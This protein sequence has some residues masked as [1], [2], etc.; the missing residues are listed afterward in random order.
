MHVRK[1]KPSIVYWLGNNIY[2][3]LTNKCSNNCYF[4]FRKYK[5]GIQDFNLRL[6]KEPTTE[7]IIEEILK[8]I[9]RRNW[10]EIVFCGFGEPLEKLDVV[11][12]VTKWIKKNYWN[13]VRVDTNGQGYLLNK[14]RDVVR[15]LKEARVDKF[16]ISLNAQNK[17]TYN[18]ICKPAF[19]YAYESVLEFIK[20]AKKAGIETVITAVSIPEIDISKIKEQA[21]RMG[22]KF[23][24]RKYIPFFW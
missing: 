3:N 18:Q 15:E 13:L 8:V 21:K 6:E 11:L 17:K 12:E 9:N 1:K 2:L 14:G 24:I 10:N 5:K 7:G 20:N 16:N 23:S 4:C 19:E 22:V